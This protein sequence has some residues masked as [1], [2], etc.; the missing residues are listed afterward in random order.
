MKKV[1]LPLLI[2]AA[3]SML[4]AVESAPSAIVGYVKYPCVVGDNL[5]ALPMDPGT[6]MT[7]SVVG[8]AYPLLNS[9]ATWSPGQFWDA[10]QAYDDGN[11]GFVW[12]PDY[13]YTTGTGLFV[14][15]STD[16]NFYSMGTVPASPV[17]PLVVGD[18]LVTVP[19][20]RSD[21]TDTGLIGATSTNF[22]SI[23]LWDAGQFWNA[24]QAYDD[25]EGGFVWD[26][27]LTTAIGTPFM[28]NSITDFSWPSA[29]G[30][31][32]TVHSSKISKK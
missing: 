5:I 30:V 16:F 4:I 9:M 32:T 31:T 19:L 14:N 13:E 23:A 8:L 3:F 22:N 24:S 11:G 2:L 12:D 18:N 20:N 1:L 21:L 15:T 29:K 28:V 10:S 25:G 26:P 17:Y 6:T 7:S 27:L